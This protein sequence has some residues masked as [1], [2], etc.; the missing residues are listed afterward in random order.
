MNRGWW[1][2][3][4]FL[5]TIWFFG[6]AVYGYSKIWLPAVCFSFASVSVAEKIPPDQKAHVEDTQKKARSGKICEDNTWPSLLNIEGLAK[7]KLVS[8]VGV[9]WLGPSGWSLER[10][11]LDVFNEGEITSEIILRRITSIVY[12]E[13]LEALYLTIVVVASIPFVFLLVGIGFSWV[14]KGFRARP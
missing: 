4:L 13:R 12:R 2:L 11:T 6:W 8:Q 1:R 9:Q 14:R 7:D 5:S 3:W 10:G